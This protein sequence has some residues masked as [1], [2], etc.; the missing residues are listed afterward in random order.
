MKARELIECLMRFDLDKRVG[1]VVET[2]VP[3]TETDIQFVEV[4]DT[5]SV[6]GERISIGFVPNVIVKLSV[7]PK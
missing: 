7:N 2:Q 6:S 1:F 3:G 4:E 5:V